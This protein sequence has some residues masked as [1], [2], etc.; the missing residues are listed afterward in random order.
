MKKIIYTLLFLIH[1]SLLYAQ[2][3]QKRKCG[4]D[5]YYQRKMKT[6]TAFVRKRKIIEASTNMY[7]Q[8]QRHKPIPNSTLDV[9]V[10]TI[11]IVVHV[12]WNLPNQNISDNL[13]LSQVEALRKDFQL[14][15]DD[16]ALCPERFRN[17]QA[18]CQV[19]FCLAKR[20]PN[21]NATSG[22]ERRFTAI[23]SYAVNDNRPKFYSQGGLDAWNSEHYL[24]I[25]IVPSIE[26]FNLSGYAT[27]PGDAH[28]VDG[29]VIDWF[30][31]GVTS[32]SKGRTA[33]HEVGHWLNLKHIFSP[34]CIELDEVD[35]TPI[36]SDTYI[37]QCPSDMGVRTSC[38]GLNLPN[39]DMYMNYMSYTNDDCMNMFT[40]GQKNRMLSLFQPGGERFNLNLSLGCYPPSFIDLIVQE[41]FAHSSILTHGAQTTVSCKIK[42][43]GTLSASSSTTAVWLSQNQTFDGA[44]TDINLNA[45][46]A[47]G[48]LQPSQITS[49]L[50]S[51]ITIP[52]GLSQGSWYIMF[53]ADA[54]DQIN[55]SGYETNNQIFIPIT[56]SNSS[57]VTPF[58]NSHPVDKTVTSPVSA[59]FSIAASG[60]NNLYQWQTFINGVWSNLSNNSLYTGVYSQELNITGTSLNMSGSQFRCIVSSYCSSS[61]VTSNYAVLTVN[62]PSATCNNDFACD[63]KPL[64]IGSTCNITSCTT[65]GANPP[66]P[67]VSFLGCLGSFYQ[68][69]R[70]DDDVWFSITPTNDNPVT[71]KVTATSNLNSFDPVLGIYTGACLSLSQ[72]SGGC[73]D[74]PRGIP[75]QVTFT[76]VP[77]TTYLIRVFGYGIGSAFS[78]NFD[79][80]VTATGYSGSNPMPDLV[81]D[82]VTISTTTI[83]P[84]GSF[85]L[86]LDIENAGDASAGSSTVKYYL[87]SNST[88]SVDDVILGNSSIASL[89]SGYGISKTKTLNIPPGTSIGNWYVLIVV[90]ANNNVDEGV[91]GE[92]NNVDSKGISVITCSLADIAISYTGNP[93]TTGNVGQNVPV[94]YRCK[95]IGGSVTPP[96][97][98]GFY[99]SYDNIYDPLTDIYLSYETTA[100]LDQNEFDDEETAI[101][102]PDCLPCGNYFLIMVADFENLVSESD[103]EN[104]IY[105]FPYTFTGCVPCSVTIASTGTSF[106]SAGGTGTIPVSAYKCC[107]WN[108]TTDVNW[109]NIINGNGNGNGSVQF[110]VA[111][112]SGGGSR[113]GTITVVGNTFTI[114]QNCTEVCNN[115]YSFEWAVQAGS[116]NYHDFANDLALGND[117]SLY[118]TGSIRGSS[119]FGNGITLNTVGNTSDIFVS[120]HNS[121]GLIQWAVSF[122]SSS[123]AEGANGI[124][125]DSD[126]YIYV[127]GYT[128]ASISFGG[129]VISNNG[130]NNDAAFLL[131]L[132]H[133]GNVVWA[134]KINATNFSRPNSI[135]IDGSNNIFITGKYS[136]LGAGDGFFITKYDTN[137]N[138]NWFN[139]Y[140]MNIYTKEVY[141]I[142][143]DNSGNLIFCGRY[144]STITLGSITLTATNATLDTDGFIAKAD[145]NGNILWARKITSPGQGR[146]ELTSVTTD[147]QNNIYV[148]GNVDS[149]AIVEDIIIPLS[150]S[151]KSIII[152]YTPNGTPVW[153]KT[154]TQGWQENY[155]KVIVVNTNE[156]YLSGNFR[157]SMRIDSFLV[158]SAGIHDNYLARLD[159]NGKMIWLRSYGGTNDEQCGGFVI[160]HANNMYV[161]GSFIG[162]LTLGDTTISTIDRKDIFLAVFK[163]CDPPTASITFTGNP[164]ICPGQTISLSTDYCSTNSYQWSLNGI[165]IPGATNANYA[166]TQTGTYKV[167]V[168]AS[169]AC[170]TLSNPVILASQVTYTFNGN[171]NWSN[172]ANWS[173]NLV[174]PST[175][176]SCAEI[177]INPQVGGECRLNVPQ[178]ISAGGRITV[179][180]GC[181]FIISGNL[182]LQN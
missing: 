53:G 176:P 175:L 2:G 59:T 79:I 56:I 140:G 152:K 95:N 174:P 161:S 71:I 111:P 17:L 19:D 143:S 123:Q 29:V 43:Q 149:T 62:N 101:N 146:D 44:P 154:S 102:I 144:L 52:N 162:S 129:T 48:P 160:D 164:I 58:I 28:E 124:A 39:G 66:S 65:I 135:K 127:I 8:S 119:T 125:T 181:N 156:I 171:G 1:T 55:E 179:T 84:G 33:T 40:L 114:T 23:T 30:S 21:G 173:N 90:D 38:L 35:D 93:P 63:P 151:S 150:P 83:C 132:T 13:I 172:A 108:A 106:Q 18:N 6:D 41:G 57:C 141:S 128:D 166:A 34:A 85:Q 73:S 67:G 110:S 163:Q 80:C 61:T 136:E 49:Y 133:G 92:G 60:S 169:Q 109:I 5:E 91:S 9:P 7:I 26:N 10:I 24:N 157:E 138:Q 134:R 98:V 155:N 145:A 178:T 180:N 22:I 147:S 117:N 3:Q 153:I 87:S 120:K 36:Q 177:I 72:L 45:D 12:L 182:I 115:S 88:Y 113:S 76:P 32:D 105:V 168:T 116:S 75:E 42:N 14:S 46:I 37:N 103:R 51:S 25:W 122:G 16:A 158:T 86:N 31:F 27:F 69:G 94:T 118:L 112:C 81:A 159:E 100:P 77:G 20:D 89:G 74:N 131:K 126:G 70:Y 4:F 64:A 47:V 139:I 142:T 15:N 82:N 99:F 78:G 148:G 130:P 11:P 121:S 54:L 97:K 137:G 167:R 50:S 165:D 104:N 107:P 96:T 68:S 170:E